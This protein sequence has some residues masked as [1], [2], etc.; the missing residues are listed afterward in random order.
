MHDKK[1]KDYGREGDPF[2][3]VRASA[4]FGVPAW[5]GCTI[6]MNDKMKRLQ[7]AARGGT[8]ANE[9]VEDSLL[10]LAVYAIIALV[11]RREEYPVG[12]PK[13]QEGVVPV[14]T[15]RNSY[16]ATGEGC[17]IPFLG[18]DETREDGANVGSR[19]ALHTL[20]QR[21]I[22]HQFP[23]PDESKRIR[24]ILDGEGS[25]ARR[26]NG[27]GVHRDDRVGFLP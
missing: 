23:T 3:N 10:D 1:Q 16:F 12:K 27:A 7:K 21:T 26:K 8:M 22:D 5:I 9:S 6:R 25:T 24:D 4:D 18:R 17:G 19:K 20:V 14:D 15:G 13:L 2:A 11:L